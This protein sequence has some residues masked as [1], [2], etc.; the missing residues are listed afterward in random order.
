MRDF[1]SED[2]KDL[3]Q[4]GASKARIGRTDLRD[5]V[6]GNAVSPGTRQLQEKERQK[7]KCT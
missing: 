2:D 4:D 6:M 7:R 1:Y 3:D 5:V